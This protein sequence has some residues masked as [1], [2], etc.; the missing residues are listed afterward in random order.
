MITPDFNAYAF[1]ARAYYANPLSSRSVR[2]MV[3]GMMTSI[4]LE[5]AKEGAT[6]I[7][8]IKSVTEAD[9]K[10]FLA[11]SVVEPNG[12]VQTK[13]KMDEG[14]TEIE[15]ILNVLLYGLRR[16][17]ISE[18]VKWIAKKELG[19]SAA[20]LE[21]AELKEHSHSDMHHH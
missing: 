2:C 19:G 18:I 17:K 1:Q 7:G 20:R 14:I 15:V 10:G 13:G 11:C 8:H 21:I 12:A 4:A 9:G 5:C 3:E 16:E 6:L